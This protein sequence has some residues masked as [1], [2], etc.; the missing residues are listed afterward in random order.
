MAGYGAQDAVFQSEGA[1]DRHT[2]RFGGPHHFPG[3][4]PR[5]PGIRMLD[6]PALLDRLAENP[7]FVAQAVTHR[8]NLSVAS[9]SMKQAASRPRPPFP[10][11]A[12]G[13]DSIT[14]FQSC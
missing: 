2:H 13:S 3:I 10:R 14:S 7:V 8:R 1:G 5:Q 12:S 9:E 4:G 11:P 6:L